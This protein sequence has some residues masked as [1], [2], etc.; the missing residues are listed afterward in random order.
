[1]NV[2]VATS[3]EGDQVLFVIRSCV[4]AKVDVVDLKPGKCATDLA[5]PAIALEHSLVQLAVG[6][7]V[8]L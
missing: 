1:M 4:A 3:A 8:Q 7:S 5:F 2:D 6:I